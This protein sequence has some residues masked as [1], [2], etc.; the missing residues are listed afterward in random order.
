MFGKKKKPEILSCFLCAA[1]FEK[2]NLDKHYSEHLIEVIDDDSQ[3][4][5]GVECPKCG[6]LDRAGGQDAPAGYDVPS[7]ARLAVA[8]QLDE[9]HFLPLS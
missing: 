6:M 5:Y 2:C 7:S 1:S 9:R 3:H 4:A 8:Y